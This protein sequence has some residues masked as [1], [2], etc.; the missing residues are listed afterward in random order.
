MGTKL[1]SAAH[2]LTANV[3]C[4]LVKVKYSFD[5]YV[6]LKEVAESSVKN[7]STVPCI[8]SIQN[9]GKFSVYMKIQKLVLYGH[10][11]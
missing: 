10:E 4:I 2:D 6:S 5:K 9:G 1:C 7:I 11:A 3:K 8:N